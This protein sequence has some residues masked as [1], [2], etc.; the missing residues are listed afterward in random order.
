MRKRQYTKRLRPARAP[1]REDRAAKIQSKPG[2]SMNCISSVR[3]SNRW[4]LAIFVVVV[5]VTI[6]HYFLFPNCGC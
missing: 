6:L 1:R 4:L 5:V 3:L 2:P